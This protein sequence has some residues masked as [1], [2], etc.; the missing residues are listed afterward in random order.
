MP[1]PCSQ[2]FRED[3]V[4]VAWS[5]AEG[6]MLAQI[7]E[8]FGV[9]EMTLHTWICQADIDDGIGSS[10]HLIVR[11]PPRSLRGICTEHG[12]TQK[13]I[14]PHCP[15]QNGNVER[16]NGTLATEWAYR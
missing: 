12:T 5:R 2:E 16:L 8:G 3:V 4:R 10:G 9:H 1:A 14:S 11:Q 15:R 13:L 6:V 7:A